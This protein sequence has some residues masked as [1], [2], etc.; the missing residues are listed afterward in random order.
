MVNADKV[1]KTH[2][3]KNGLKCLIY[4]DKCFKAANVSLYVH[5]GSRNEVDKR[6][7]GISHLIEHMM[8]KGTEKRPEADA[9]SKAVYKLGGTT[10]AFTGVEITGY[11]I[12][13]P[14]HNMAGAVE[15]LSDMIYNS[16][17][18]EE[19][20]NVEKNVVVNELKQ[21]TSNPVYVLTNLVNE[22]V[23]PNLTLGKSVG[24]TCASVLRIS[25]EDV[26]KYLGEYYRCERMTLTLVGDADDKNMLK[27]AE[28]YFGK[29]MKWGRGAN[30]NGNG[31]GSVL[32]KDFYLLQPEKRV[33]VQRSK[34]DHAFICFAFPI[35][36]MTGKL[37]RAGEILG[38]V[39]AGNMMSRLFLELR[40]KRGLIY[41]VKFMMDLYKDGGTFMI[42]LSTYN[43][44]DKI[45]EVVRLVLI[46]MK[47]MKKKS[48]S[49]KELKIFKDF[50]IGNWKMELNDANEMAEFFA[51]PSILCGKVI[52]KKKYL[53]SL[54]K[55]SCRD[56][57]LAA[58]DIFRESA[59]NLCVLAK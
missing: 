38:N 35:N 10:N 50:M 4:S 3:L 37:F 52:S 32:E 59:L 2:I 28:K 47:K 56:I 7:F 41:S 30:G 21:R 22:S 53:S 39:M 5:C 24:G 55:V 20:I 17:I 9:I 57:S 44:K 48:I 19:D 58:R 1:C 13:V 16:L 26:M 40:E 11:Y 15:I 25:R 18:S 12:N 29:E 36:V 31:V 42:I 33:I 51:I 23:F 27:M 14:C 8:F 45:D 6:T 54:R 46:E 43:Q 49:K 34:L